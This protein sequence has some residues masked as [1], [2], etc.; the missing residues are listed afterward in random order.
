MTTKIQG[1]NYVNKGY[2]QKNQLRLDD[3]IVNVDHR[4]IWQQARYNGAR[5]DDGG[6]EDEEEEWRQGVVRY[7]RGLCAEF[8]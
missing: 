1:L 4:I 2:L 3:L 6:E 8:V 7:M 5:N